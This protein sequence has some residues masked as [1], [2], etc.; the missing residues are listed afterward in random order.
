MI[1]LPD[2]VKE[3]IAPSSIAA[4]A[5]DKRFGPDHAEQTKAAWKDAEVPTEVVVYEGA[6]HGFCIRGNMNDEKQ[7]AAIEGSIAQVFSFCG[8]D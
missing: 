3:P 6:D 5:E 8:V 7:K 1:S 4:A 2:D